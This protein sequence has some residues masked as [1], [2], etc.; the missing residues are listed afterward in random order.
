MNSARNRLLIVTALAIIAIAASGMVLLHQRLFDSLQLQRYS[1]EL[2]YYQSTYLHKQGWTKLYPG[3]G[4]DG[5]GY[6]LRSFDRGQTW[7]AIDTNQRDRVVILGLA[8]DV[9]PGLLQQEAGL[10]ALIEYAKKHG[11][12]NL[13]GEDA[14]QQ[15][16]LLRDSG[17]TVEKR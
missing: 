9:Y 17:F 7:Y 16:N 1:R 4:A 13:T 2:S 10:A 11:P 5:L 3:S 15:L 6:D 8:E 12:I 14:A